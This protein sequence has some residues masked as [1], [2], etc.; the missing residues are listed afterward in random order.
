MTAILESMGAW[1]FGTLAFPL[2]LWTI[3]AGVLVL[4][5]V[6][7]VPARF[8]RI[9]SDLLVAAILA[10]PLALAMPPTLEIQ[11][12]V[13]TTELSTPAPLSAEASVIVVD[14]VGE[15]TAT[16]APASQSAVSSGATGSPLGAASVVVLV[17]LLGTGYLFV[18]LAWGWVVI[19]RIRRRSEPIEGM[20]GSVPVCQSP[21]VQIPFATGLLR[22]VIIVP[23]THGSIAKGL[24]LVVKHELAHIAAGDIWVLRLS[25]V[26][27]AVF[28]PHPL[29]WL[30]MNRS[31]TYREQA[32][33]AVAT[34][35]QSKE[36]YATLLRMYA[37][38]KALLGPSMAGSS[39]RCRLRMLAG[40]TNAYQ[41]GRR[42]RSLIPAVVLLLGVVSG[43][44]IVDMRPSDD[45]AVIFRGDVSESQMRATVWDL[46]LEGDQVDWGALRPVRVDLR[47]PEPPSSAD[48]NLL[49]ADTRVRNI[50][51]PRYAACFGPSAAGGDRMWFYLTVQFDPQT[52]GDEARRVVNQYL[53]G[54][55]CDTTK[56]PN[57]VVLSG[58]PRSDRAAVIESLTANPLVASVDGMLT[59]STQIDQ[60]ADPA[61]GPYRKAGAGNFSFEVPS[62]WDLISSK[63]TAGLEGQ[64]IVGF[65]I[66]AEEGDIAVQIETWD[67]RITPVYL[68]P[69]WGGGKYL[70]TI[71]RAREI[72][73]IAEILSDPSAKPT[74]AVVSTSGGRTFQARYGASGNKRYVIL[75]GGDSDAHTIFHLGRVER[76]IQFEPTPDGLIA[77]SIEASLLSLNFFYEL[78]SENDTAA[79]PNKETLELARANAALAHRRAEEVLGSPISRMFRPQVSS[80]DRSVDE[81]R[82]LGYQ[83]GKFATGYADAF[84]NRTQDVEHYLDIKAQLAIWDQMV[85]KYAERWL[86]E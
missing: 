51:V 31:S 75:A 15:S 16:S 33:D 25:L 12:P 28:W 72:T 67:A 21:E 3:A 32:C 84:A 42:L 44:R 47:L 43:C 81:L 58:V 59:Q 27:R 71:S 48:I 1:A 56:R 17:W 69:E 22:P 20:K 53:G 14:P 13:E 80:G 2:L 79:A 86:T 68:A 45:I 74:G 82:F 6:F 77:E 5:V 41:M 26:L 57:E 62:S 34:R 40:E 61:E 24:D 85:K 55:A 66:G 46:G 39:I 35:G 11:R 78:V 19:E 37:S 76:S 9:R 64:Q 30:L 18:R 4:V 50:S 60:A 7:L 49:Y 54:E 73:S 23:A 52:Q 83:A 29:V 38:R 65:M 63:L 36:E 10:L 70:D 8:A